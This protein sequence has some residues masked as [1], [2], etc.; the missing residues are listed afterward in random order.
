MTDARTNR[1]IL[2]LAALGFFAAGAASLYV[3]AADPQ[4]PDFLFGA[5]RLRNVALASVLF[6]LAAAFFAAWISR[7]AAIAFW[8]SLLPVLLVLVLLE[9][10]GRMGLVDWSG[11]L[12]PERATA[13]GPGWSLQPNASVAG[14]T[15]QDAATRYGVP[16]DPIP[17]AFETDSYGFRNDGT[18][19]ADI[20]ILGDSIV[21]GALVPKSQTVDS[22]VSEA[23]A[24]PVSQAALLGIS[25][26]RQ[27]D[28]LR[29]AGIS[30]EG[31]RVVQFF[32]EGND[33]LD[34]HSY[35]N[36]A[37]ADAFVYKERSLLKLLWAPLV[38]LTSNPGDFASC[39]IG[40]QAHYF[41]WTRNSFEGRME[42]FGPISEAILAFKQMVED[43]GGTYALVFVPTK[44]R[45]LHDLCAFPERSLISDP[46]EQLSDIPQIVAGWADGAGIAFLDLTEPLQSRAAEGVSPW[47]W[48]DTHWN[49][50]GHKVA[51]ETIARWLEADL[52]Q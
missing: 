29:D 51:G 23:L 3:S 27:H 11:L 22:V 16:H 28:M 41:I 6:V 47:F 14:E 2:I 21:L 33:L 13:E 26:Q 8:A 39:R 36:P 43:A 46:A 9:G 42:E 34:S 12:S 19:V 17:F 48:G 20:I 37:P 50:E 18:D 10:V 4:S 49:T 45:V 30:L 32:F 40:E 44:Y 25:I 15:Y 35:R 31:R 24:R 38:R 1:W 7:S 5:W 52:A